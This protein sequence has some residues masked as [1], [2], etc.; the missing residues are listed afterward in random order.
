VGYPKTDSSPTGTT[1]EQLWK[2][3]PALKGVGLSAL[4]GGNVKITPHK[5]VGQALE[6][7]IVVGEKQ[8]VPLVR[9]SLELAC[10]LEILFLRR[11]K[12]GSLVSFFKAVTLIIES[13]HSLM[14]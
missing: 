11:G 8:F 14:L 1:L 7:P 12:L 6:K 4:L 10:E 3:H 2:T 13:R 9:E 5:V